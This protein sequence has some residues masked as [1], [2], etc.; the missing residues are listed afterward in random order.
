MRIRCQ[1]LTVANTEHAFEASGIHAVNYRQAVP[2]SAIP[3]DP[4]VL[5]TP[6]NTSQLRR[7]AKHLSDTTDLH[8]TAGSLAKKLNKAI[9]TNYGLEALD[10]A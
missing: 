2:P 6:S 5:Q 9:Q 10:A 8:A 3:D 1:A 4:D 7:M